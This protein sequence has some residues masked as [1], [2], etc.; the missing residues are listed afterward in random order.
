MIKENES[1]K[2]SFF[3]YII[4]SIAAQ[5]VF[6][7][8]TM[9][10]AIFVARGVS[11]TALAAVN[12]C[13]PFITALFAISIVAAVGT[14]T[15]V[16][17]LY[18][19]GKSDDASALFSM[20]FSVALIVSVFITAA[21]LIWTEEFANLLGATN[22]TR[23]YVVT[24]LRTVAPFSVFFILSYIFEILLAVDGYPAKATRIVSIGVVS[25]FILDYLLIFV[26]KWEIFGAALATGVSQ[27]FIMIIYLFHFLGPK[28]SIKFSRFKFVWKEIIGSFYRGLPSGVMEIS[29]GIITFILIHFVETNLGEDGLITFSSM[30][31]MAGVMIIMA[32]GVGQGTQPLISYYNGKRDWT[33]I[34]KLF[35][36]EIITGISLE[37]VIY[38]GVCI[39]S[40]SFASLFLKGDAEALIGYTASMMKYYLFFTVIDG[41]V[42]ITSI[43]LTALERPLPGI[44]FA[45]LRCTIFLVIGCLITTAIGG[46][47]IWFAMIVAELQTVIGYAILLKRKRY[48]KGV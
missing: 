42:V 17:R 34:R 41:L 32:V 4:P 45:S 36:Y 40:T 26:I 8:Y 20:N 22:N 27:L 10:D 11:A 29:P 19:E 6:T 16:A 18:G 44:V 7:L 35:K 1:L 28:G 24:Y 14:S 30:A 3:K 5:L 9:V 47:A 33:S 15:Q 31:Y 23:G 2:I 37:V 38:L 43:T 46:N 25:N 21:A 12:I 39:F 48:F 13:A